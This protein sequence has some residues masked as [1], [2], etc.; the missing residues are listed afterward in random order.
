MYASPFNAER[1]PEAPGIPE[2]VHLSAEAAMVL[3]QLR[4][5]RPNPLD[6]NAATP[7]EKSTALARAIFDH[8]AARLTLDL[9]DDQMDLPVALH[10]DDPRLLQLLDTARQIQQR[11]PAAWPMLMDMALEAV[12]AE[13]ADVMGLDENGLDARDLDNQNM[14]LYE[15]IH[16]DMLDHRLETRYQGILNPGT[17]AAPLTTPWMPPL[18]GTV[19]GVLPVRPTPMPEASMQSAAP[20]PGATI[21]GASPL[22]GTQVTSQD[23]PMS[24]EQSEQPQPQRQ[25]RAVMSDYQIREVTDPETQ[26]VTYRAMMVGVPENQGTLSRIWASAAQNEELPVGE[27]ASRAAAQ[28]HVNWLQ[29]EEMN[30]LR[31]QIRQAQPLTIAGVPYEPVL[32]DDGGLTHYIVNDSLQ[33]TAMPLIAPWELQQYLHTGTL[34]P[35]MATQQWQNAASS[36]HEFTG[37]ERM[38]LQRFARE[39]DADPRFQRYH[40]QEG[41]YLVYL[42]GSRANARN[43]SLA[44][45]PPSMQTFVQENRFS[46]DPVI[47]SNV[48]GVLPVRPSPSQ[49]ANPLQPA[50]P[51]PETLSA[52]PE[53]PAY[54]EQPQPQAAERSAAMPDYQIREITDPAT[55]Q[56]SY[57]TELNH[58]SQ[59]FPA[60]SRVWGMDAENDTL[61][62]GTF[63]SMEAAQAQLD[64]LQNMEPLRE[65]L[66]NL[67]TVTIAGVPYD[68]VSEDNGSISRFLARDGM[69]RTDLPWIS[70]WELQQYAHTGKLTPEL[71]VQQLQSAELSGY[72]F[73]PFETLALQEFARDAYVD[74][75]FTAYRKQEGEYHA[76]R[77]DTRPSERDFSLDELPRVIRD[78]VWAHRFDLHQA[79]TTQRP[80]NREQRQESGLREAPSAGVQSI[81]GVQPPNAARTT[82]TGLRLQ[83]LYLPDA[84]HKPM[85]ID[86]AFRES[87]FIRAFYNTSDALAFMGWVDAQKE[88][89]AALDRGGPLTLGQLRYVPAGVPGEYRATDAET[90][91]PIDRQIIDQST[92]HDLLH[93]GVVRDDLA[94][95]W[96]LCPDL[97]TPIL[98]TIVAH[99]QKGMYD[100]ASVADEISRYAPGGIAAS[101]QTPPVQPVSS[102]P[103]NPPASPAQASAQP[104][105]AA[106]NFAPSAAEQQA[107]EP[108]EN[109]QDMDYK[110]EATAGAATN[111]Q[112]VVGENDA[113]PVKQE[114]TQKAQNDGREGQQK[115]QKSQQGNQAENDGKN[116][117]GQ[118][119]G[120]SSDKPAQD[121]PKG[122]GGFSLFSRA[123]Q[124]H[125]HYNEEKPAAPVAPEAFSSGA[126]PSQGAAPSPDATPQG[127]TPPQ[128]SKR[129][130][131]GVMDMMNQA[132][133]SPEEINVMNNRVKKEGLTPEIQKG[134]ENLSARGQRDVK[135][136]KLTPEQIQKNTHAMN[137]LADTVNRQPDSP[138]KDSVMEHIRKLVEMLVEAIKR[139]FSRG[140]ASA[141]PSM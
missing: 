116:Q 141:G 82:E 89:R 28:E 19:H 13:T 61:P 47:A 5:T 17:L 129:D 6:W 7:I 136:G 37:P 122:G 133:V 90:G 11:H 81:A 33:R 45:L 96:Q 117:K 103:Q 97:L 36:G 115:D 72:D 59:N 127:T 109:P 104:T 56:V 67:E 49:G 58:V 121:A 54:T 111:K 93:N 85:R 84:H 83:D 88:Q 10:M 108:A 92:L 99:R 63:D 112:N 73:T 42:G 62:L 80:E 77:G 30:G 16:E 107:Q 68:P 87:D 119:Q 40:A 55:Q 2:P 3:Q 44:D 76:A 75:Q 94:Q 120:Q 106:G 110:D 43:F 70:P 34:S 137:Q 101:P 66:R 18:P 105:P 69:D 138:Q 135:D 134:I 29:S 12:Q 31:E 51:M 23:R 1:F 20:M 113:T 140:R 86:T 50:S 126:S 65:A 38:A 74:P 132:P 46:T 125:H 39:A 139:I 98:Q 14:P 9:P 124:H 48:Q 24:P 130:T 102:S 131:M 26:A 57:Q 118:G 64:A 25:R 95:Q 52:S 8:E 79:V 27:F 91:Q 71:A 41:D 114:K 21:P 32:N 100:Y 60:G 128:V 78:Y 35:E 53:F 4:S 123:P 15:T 22:P